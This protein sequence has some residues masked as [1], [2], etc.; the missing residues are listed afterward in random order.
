MAAEDR[1]T[2]VG[3]GPAT[4][5]AAPP[6]GDGWA[7]RIVYLGLYFW[8][9][10]IVLGHKPVF[11]SNYGM[12]ADS[13]PEL[14]TVVHRDRADLHDDFDLAWCLRPGM[15]VVYDRSLIVGVSARPRDQTMGKGLWRRVRMGFHTFGFEWREWPPARPVAGATERNRP[16]GN[17]CVAGGRLPTAGLIAQ[18]R[19]ASGPQPGCLEQRRACRARAG[20]VR[21]RTG[22][23][24]SGTPRGAPRWRSRT[25]RAARSA[26]G[27]ATPTATSFGMVDAVISPRRSGVCIMSAMMSSTLSRRVSANRSRTNPSR[28]G[29]TRFRLLRRPHSMSD[30]P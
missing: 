13:W 4:S 14:R 16:V 5:T 26:R 22:C 9:L 30:A 29:G 1:P 6:R 15:S 7:G 2:I 25:Q 10:G 8:G 24:P 19:R 3:C 20:G 18:A 23:A 12:R 21:S 27:H 17:G 28:P 11:G